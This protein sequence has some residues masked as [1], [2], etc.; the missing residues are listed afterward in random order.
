MVFL[1]Y[2][3]LKKPKRFRSLRARSKKTKNPHFRRQNRF[4]HVL[5]H[6]SN[7]ESATKQEGGTTGTTTNWVPHPE[8][9][10][11]ITQKIFA[12]ATLAVVF[13]Y[14]TFTTLSDAPNTYL[15]Q[16]AKNL[17]RWTLEKID[18][19]GPIPQF[20]VKTFFRPHFKIC[21]ERKLPR[22]AR[23]LTTPL[24]YVTSLRF[25]GYPTSWL[26]FII[27]KKAVDDISQS[28]SLHKILTKFRVDVT[29]SSFEQFA[30]FFN[31]SSFHSNL[32]P[33]MDWNITHFWFSF[34]IR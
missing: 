34:S 25:I 4:E 32:K 9:R 8:K 33:L 11:I 3:E 1:R 29:F 2:S 7:D 12:R 16:V 26:V 28:K 15:C 30:D 19:C 6:V 5:L 22:P 17:S 20:W 18:T 13:L 31:I 27:T 23:D 14:T 10:K 24:I 21:A